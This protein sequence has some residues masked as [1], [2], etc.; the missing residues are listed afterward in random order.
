MSVIKEICNY[1]NNLTVWK[2]FDFGLCFQQIFIVS[3]AYLQLCIIGLY[4][5]F[6]AIGN[7]SSQTVNRSWI[8]LLRAGCHVCTICCQIYIIAEQVFALKESSIIALVVNSLILIAWASSLLSIFLWRNGS[9]SLEYG[10]DF[11]AL[12][13]S[14]V[15]VMIS[16][17]FELYSAI[18]YASGNSSPLNESNIPFNESINIY[19]RWVMYVAILLLQ[20]P[21]ANETYED[22]YIGVLNDEQE[23]S[24]SHEYL[25]MPNSTL[26]EDSF[27]NISRIF[28][29]WVSKLFSDAKF[30]QF[31]SVNDLSF[32][33]PHSM[34]PVTNHCNLKLA[35][36]HYTQSHINSP[37]EYDDLIEPLIKDLEDRSRVHNDQN[38]DRF[39]LLKSLNKA[40][41]WS[42]WPL[43]LIKLISAI[44]E[45]SL[46]I[47]LNLFLREL[48]SD[49]G[50]ISSVAIYLG[51]LVLIVILNAF[52]DTHLTY[53][54]DKLKISMRGCVITELFAKVLSINWAGFRSCSIGEITNFAA[55][56][57]DNI[58]SHIV[59]LFE[60]WYLPLKLVLIFF[61]LYNYVGISFLAGIGLCILLIPLNQVI[62][63]KLHRYNDRLMSHRD[64]RLKLLHEIMGNM[65]SIK[66]FA[67][68]EQF[69]GKVEKLRNQEIVEL[70]KI[71]YFDAICVYFW[72]SAPCLITFFII[73]TYVFMGNDI[74]ASTIF[75]TL[76]LVD[77]VIL[78]LNAL[79]WV[80]MGFIKTFISL[81]RVQE[82]FSLKDNAPT[83]VPLP[84]PFEEHNAI[85]VDNCSFY[86]KNS[87]DCC[88]IGLQFQV[89]KGELMAVTGKTGSGKTSLLLALSQEL[90]Y[91]GEM[92]LNGWKDGIGIVLQD[93]WIKSG[94]IKEA[95][96]D[97]GVL[98]LDWYERVLC[99]CALDKD[100]ACFPDGHNTSVGVDGSAL[101]G[102]QQLRLALARA[103]YKNKEIY[104]I[105]DI[106]SGL[107]SHVVLHI[108]DKC[109][110]GLLSN[111]TR[112][113][114][115]HNKLLA[116]S[117]DTLLALENKQIKYI[118]LPQM[119]DSSEITNNVCTTDVHDS[120]PIEEETEN[121]IIQFSEPRQF[122]PVKINVYQH[123][124]A[125][126]GFFLTS[127]VLVSLVGMQ[128]SSTLS[129]WWLSF[130]IKST[131][132]SPDCQLRP[133]NSSQFVLWGIF[134]NLQCVNYYGTTMVLSNHYAAHNSSGK[135]F[136]LE[137]YGSLITANTIFTLIRAFSFA[138]FGISAT[139]KMHRDMLK[140][141]MKSALHFFD[142]TPVGVIINR[143]SSDIYSVD[144][145]LPFTLN[146][147]LAELF[148]LIG[149]LVMTS[150]GLPYV[151]IAIIPLLVIYRCIQKYY[152]TAVREVKRLYSITQSPLFNH[153]DATA[154]GL[155]YI[156]SFRTNNSA[157][158]VGV[159]YLEAFQRTNFCLCAASAW[160]G[161]RLQFLAG[162]I[163]GLVSAVILIEMHYHV[164]DAT[165]LGLAMTYALSINST[166][167]NLIISLTEV[168][169]EFI[170][171]ERI[172]QYTHG[173]PIEIEDND[174]QVVDFTWPS[175]GAIQFSDVSVQYKDCENRAL[176]D[177]S[178][179]VKPGEKVAIV[180]RTGAGKSTIFLTLFKLLDLES[181][182]IIIDNV[183]I[184]NLSNQFLRKHIA[185]IP[186]KPLVFTGTVRENLD[187]FSRYEDGKIFECLKKC[188]LPDFSLDG[189]IS[190]KTLSSGQSQLISL[191]R[192]LLEKSKILCL[193]EATSNVDLQTNKTIKKIIEEEYCNSTILTIAHR[194]ENVMDYDRVLVVGHGEI[195][196]NGN[197]K[198]LIQDKNSLFYNLALSSRFDVSTYFINNDLLT[199]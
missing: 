23:A 189:L 81:M 57:S 67:W 55:Q 31:S 69:I 146:I 141:V 102:G 45:I 29:C 64:S 169:K 162:S 144:S 38:V 143:F 145:S 30:N 119:F 59:C 113:I 112:V 95:I 49:S 97:G 124:S 58:T 116:N 191:A 73:L 88:L 179:S 11:N 151:L 133:S 100:I 168:E 22:P 178:F 118:G 51:L 171:A 54:V 83:K 135:M 154:N 114:C 61:L 105:D 125:A 150:Y 101:S 187:P 91:T 62:A 33:L 196:E 75:T 27:S 173:L 131:S 71:A 70:K 174:I 127:I 25:H 140:S 195:A 46:P 93:C 183:N 17:S 161:L 86:W 139:T 121:Q 182:N 16:C 136:Y 19:I 107:D 34:H 1:E 98:D 111:K 65:K 129:N 132:I 84:P 147:F 186:Q 108:I 199:L 52:I 60:I 120:N 85:E 148:I 79:P 18:L 82:F 181:G 21:K 72:A 96:V 172:L 5:C 194:L 2:D 32:V 192:V 26:S 76:A 137:V 134:T 163:V 48:E 44:F 99:A 177:I 115:S 42:F 167:K 166:L 24:S 8:I 28:F 149:T 15:I 56:D 9:H 41:G 160:L 66:F 68:E 159:K 47:L 89:N 3:P 78:P 109:I 4:Y 63:K 184:K 175:S 190:S 158:T 40:F 104:L 36:N 7:N 153:L 77:Q 10:R 193:D 164:A 170:G 155:I 37:M 6:K 165:I 197:P 80:I 123:Y 142:E 103:V 87:E 156:N 180:G 122:G 188:Q 13:F 14:W 39:L 53:E 152:I 126:A 106:F 20:L 43:N 130:W 12:K 117:A 128:V 138:T 50:S 176:N 110:N 198:D 35:I 74:S 185:I 157:F 94:S 92:R 90:N